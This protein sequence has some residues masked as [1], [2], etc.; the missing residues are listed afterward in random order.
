MMFDWKLWYPNL[1]FHQ[2]FFMENWPAPSPDQ[3]YG[4]LF[5]GICDSDAGEPLRYEL[6]IGPAKQF[7]FW[8]TLDSHLQYKGKSQYSCGE[9]IPGPLCGLTVRLQ[10]TAAIIANVALDPRLPA[11][12]SIIVGDHAPPFTESKLRRMFS[13]AEV[14]FI[15]LLLR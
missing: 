1:G 6:L 7:V 4:S 14:P 10:R 12:R 2:E 9:E 5:V 13:D 15:E 11:T 3:R 8:L